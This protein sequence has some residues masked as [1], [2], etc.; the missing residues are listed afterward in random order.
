MMRQEV[1]VHTKTG[2]SLRGVLTSR[3]GRW[4]VLKQPSVFIDADHTEPLEGEAWVDRAN[5]D[6]IQVF[7]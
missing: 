7:R 1:V 3:R 4:V 5:V 6:F 2:N